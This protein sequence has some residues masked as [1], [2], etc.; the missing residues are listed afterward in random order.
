MK[1]FVLV[2]SDHDWYK[3]VGVYAKRE[4]AQQQVDAAKL[5]QDEII[6][7]LKCRGTGPLGPWQLRG[8]E[9][10]EWY[11]VCKMKSGEVHEHEVIE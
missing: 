7:D 5:R 2:Q 4:A 11:A 1:V 3:V 8:A 6:A 9:E 10:D